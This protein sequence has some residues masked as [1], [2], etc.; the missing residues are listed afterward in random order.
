MIVDSQ[1]V[2]AELKTLRKG[3]GCYAND[4][5]ERIGQTMRELCGVLPDDNA[6]ETRRKVVNR[7]AELAKMLPTDLAVAVRA[8][9]ALTED[10]RQ[11]FYNARIDEAAR[12]IDR[13]AR[14]VRRR[15]DDGLVQL[16]DLAAE[17]VAESTSERPRPGST[18]WHTDRL[19]VYVTLDGPVPEVLEFR[20]IV[21]DFDG[22]TELDLAVSLTSDGTGDH[23]RTDVL[24]GGR[25]TRQEM[26]TSDRYGLFL[27]LP[28]PLNRGDRHE[29]LL[30]FRA[31]LEPFY[32]CVLRH[33]CRRFDL[34]VHFCADDPPREVWL[35]DGT[36][37]NDATHGGAG[38]VAVP[39]DEVGEV[40]V[41]FTNLQPAF[42]YGLKWDTGAGITS[43]DS[44]ARATESPR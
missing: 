26:Q 37:Q 29:I 17:S 9:L 19:S 11:Q 41:D 38:D 4:I 25:L 43:A 20:E 12:M 3:R 40:H 22:L 34:H 10:F 18:K 8:G 31:R 44:P 30:R 35:L 32:V 27:T 23:L 2:I 33:H 42:A 1:A 39:V 7:L 24:S 21:S 36:F 28:R 5:G 6:A 16:A 15:V 14:T 13:D